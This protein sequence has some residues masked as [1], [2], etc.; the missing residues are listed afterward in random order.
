MELDDLTVEPGSA[1]DA[2][3]ALTPPTRLRLEI[4]TVRLSGFFPIF[5]VQKV[6]VVQLILAI[7]ETN[8][9]F[10]IFRRAGAACYLCLRVVL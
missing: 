8:F 5:Q 4:P 10:G 1:V 3:A 2:T 6:C 7:G 9:A